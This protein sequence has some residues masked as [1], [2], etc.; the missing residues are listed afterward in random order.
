MDQKKDEAGHPKAMRIP[1]EAPPG[2]EVDNRGEPIPLDERTKDDQKK[3]GQAIEDAV[4]HGFKIAVS[5]EK[6]DTEDGFAIVHGTKFVLVD[7]KRQIRGYYISSD[8]DF[9]KRLLHDIKQLQSER[10]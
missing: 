9:P 7:A 6:D 5:R 1:K 2:I 10:S 4:V 3:V 8:D